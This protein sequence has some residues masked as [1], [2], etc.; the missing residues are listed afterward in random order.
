MTIDPTQNIAF[1]SYYHSN[2]QNRQSRRDSA[3]GNNMS[4]VMEEETLHN[5]E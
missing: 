1:Y 4:G 3:L 2:Q 5:T